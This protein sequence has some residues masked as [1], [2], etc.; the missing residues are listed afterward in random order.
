MIPHELLKK[1]QEL[2]SKGLS[3]YDIAD[4]LKVQPDTVVW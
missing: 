1:A 4:E 3:N 2:K